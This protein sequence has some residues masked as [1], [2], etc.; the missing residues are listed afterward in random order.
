MAKLKANIH[1]I[2]HSVPNFVPDI[3]WGTMAISLTKTKQNKKNVLPSGNLHSGVEK[4]DNKHNKHTQK[5]TSA[6][7]KVAVCMLVSFLLYDGSVEV[8]NN[9][10]CFHKA[11]RYW[12][13]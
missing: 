2:V 1:W 9:T 11:F 7:Q 4:A 8:M 13:N 3:V 10:S 5:M 6:L 12:H